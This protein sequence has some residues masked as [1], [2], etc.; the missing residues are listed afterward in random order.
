MVMKKI[1]YLFTIFFLMTGVC[2]AEKWDEHTRPSHSV[3]SF[4][5]RVIENK[6]YLHPGMAQIGPIGIT[7]LINGELVPVP[8]IESDGYGVFVRVQHLAAKV[9]E[10][11]WCCTDCWNWNSSNRMTCWWCGADRED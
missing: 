5:G 7:V 2:F 9:K 11:D 10:G 6:V 8:T 4:R 1:F 3:K